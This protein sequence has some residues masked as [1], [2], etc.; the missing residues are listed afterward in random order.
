M[1]DFSLRLIA[2][3]GRHFFRHDLFYFN[4][5]GIAMFVRNSWYVI[6]GS[7]EVTTT[8]LA[9]KILGDS[10]VIYRN[11]SGRPV[12]LE[13][14]CPHRH[15]PLS[16]GTVQGD[17]IRCG[18]HGMKFDASGECVEVPNQ[19][20]I[21]NKACVRA[22]PVE[23]RF[24]WIWIWTGDKDE[25]DV[26]LIPDFSV[27]SRPDRKSVGKTN[28][29]KANYQLVT[30]NLMD[31]SHV[32]FVH[33]TTIGNNEMGEKGSMRLTPTEAG[34]R[35]VRHI[36]DVPPP[37]TYLR[38]KQLPIGKNIDRWNV[39]E[40]MAPCFIIIHVG[41]KVAGCG[42]L[43]GD[44]EGGLNMWVCNAMTPETETSTHYFWASVREFALD[45]TEVDDLLFSNVSEAFEEDRVVLETQQRVIAEC[46]DSWSSALKADAGCL[47]ARRVVDRLLREERHKTEQ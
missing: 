9:R 32:A 35:V 15:L 42:A 30:D 44:Y 23:E 34:V 19:D 25:A 14:R 18:Y 45:S 40:F 37:P 29:V 31:L 6:G 8:P 10:V 7:D 47:Q 4:P 11:L 12:A 38:T 46:G 16:M 43:D 26:S 5:K 3:F 13:D 1:T 2:S 33:T 36:N 24:G 20:N 39:I 27:M 41:G 22:Y 28:Y 17:E 21:P